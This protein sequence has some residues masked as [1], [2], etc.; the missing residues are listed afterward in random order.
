M[1]EL[2]L[3]GEQDEQMLEELQSTV[4]ALKEITRKYEE[5]FEEV[6]C[7]W[8]EHRQELLS[9]F[10]YEKDAHGFSERDYADSFY[11]HL[12]SMAEFLRQKPKQF[13]DTIDIARHF[14]CA[15][16]SKMMDDEKD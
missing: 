11:T 12:Y 7:L 8:R 4:D 1:K 16:C 14:V 6:S 9:E 15:R 5:R 10:D 3:Y 2:V 13:Q